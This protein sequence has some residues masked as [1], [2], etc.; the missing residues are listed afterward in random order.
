MH[1]KSQVRNYVLFRGVFG[2]YCPAMAKSQNDK[3]LLGEAAEHLVLAGLLRRGHVASQAPRAWK[4][5]DILGRDGLRIQV[6]ATD[7][8]KQH[9]WMVGNV[10]ADPRRFYALVD[11]SDV[12]DPHVYIVPSI[13]IREAAEEADREGHRLHPHAKQ[14]GM[15]KVQ[16]PYPY[17]V[18][19]Y[20]K[21]WLEDYR[22][23]WTQLI[24]YV[25]TPGLLL[26]AKATSHWA[27]VRCIAAPHG[28][29][30]FPN[31][32]SAGPRLVRR[33]PALMRGALAEDRLR[34]S[35]SGGGTRHS[36][37]LISSHPPPARYMAP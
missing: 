15:R 8:G 17:Y 27:A 36:P 31:R 21:G 25:I 5:D 18:N 4:A 34:K 23:Q 1:M 26:R 16:D 9:S 33:V 29:T 10:E 3:V 6:K 30:D 28:R 20:K 32:A 11:F 14:T 2:C 35:R 24:Q 22:D 37:G 13:T 19:G 7:K 12:Q